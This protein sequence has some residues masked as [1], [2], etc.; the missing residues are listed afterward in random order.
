MEAVDLSFPVDVAAVP[1]F[2]GL[3]SL[4]RAGVT[5]KEIEPCDS[6]HVSVRVSAYA[7]ACSSSLTDKEV[8]NA[9]STSEYESTK[10]GD[11]M[12]QRKNKG[13]ESS[14]HLHGRGKNGFLLDTGA[15][16]VRL[17][18]P[19]KVSKLVSL[20]SKRP[21]VDRLEDP[22]SVA[23]E[24][25]GI[26]DMSFKL[27]PLLTKCGSSDK[28]QLVKPKNNFTSKR[29]EKRNL[30][31]PAK[32]KQD[33]FSI[34]PGLASFSSAA[35]GNNFYGVHGLK[36]DNHD[37][38]KLVDDVPLNELLDGTYKCPSL[39]RGKG[40]KPANVNDSFL[41]AVKK[42]CST[43]QQP[44]SVQPQLTAEVESNSDRVMSPW[45][46]SMTSVVASGVDG[47]KGEPF[48][49][50]LSSCNEDSHRKPVA[51]VNPL[52]LPLCE[53]KYVLERL[54]LPPHKDLESLLLDAAKPASSSKNTPDPSSGKQISRRASL[55]SFPWSHTSNGHCRSSSDAAKQ[56]ISR[57]TCQG[58][59]L[60]IDKNILSSLGNATDNLTD[61]ESVT[62]D[63]S[64]VPSARL[65]VS[66]SQ[67]K[68]SPSI[69]V[70]L[71]RCQRDSI[72]NTTPSNDSYIPQESEGKLNHSGDC[73]DENCPKVLSAAQTLCDMA[74]RT[75]RKN[76]DGIIRWPKKPSQKA[77]K[78]RKLKSIEKSEEAYGT[79]VAVSG[80]DNP[81]RSVDQML[82]PKK[83]KL[84]LID[85]NRDF[86]NFSSVRKGT[87]T[88]STPRS[89]RSS[90]SRSVKE[91]VVDIKH[92]T[93][94]VVKHSY[95]MPP[96]ARVLEKT[97]N[98][99][100]KQGK[101]LTT[102]WNKGRDRLE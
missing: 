100:E 80:S 91:S 49:T 97:S 88:W 21:R 15:E 18:K 98:K 28:T 93:A 59:W 99:R 75:S 68:V 11:L 22:T 76:P 52:D 72:S 43:L 95:M 56:S 29:G 58:R 78:A 63:Q 39:S 50:D 44:R 1:K 101:L 53:P 45:P 73:N 33:S 87:I 96:P 83:P 54:A 64:L 27:G 31:L 65:K 25:D 94:D 37:V 34:K 47:D 8:T 82:P 6:D 3:D 71:S 62:Y 86:T 102:E 40:K 17:E 13:E 84:S 24:V 2:L 69:S 74:T 77:M 35:G 46:L 10:L 61:L 41:H 19:G 20:S 67:N 5:V 90:P 12:S 42:A 92:S 32:T 66:G 38:T 81:R 85:D 89:S 7:E 55:P 4:V 9:I 51:P 16:S 23:A 48:I 26:K 70:S 57:G 79:S 36:S 14:R 60:R 30:K